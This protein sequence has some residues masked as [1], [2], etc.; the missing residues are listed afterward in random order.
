MKLPRRRFLHL[1]AGA[2][3]LPAVSRVA[4]AQ[5]YP[6]RPVHLIVGFAAGGPNDIFARLIAQWLSERLG[7]PFVIENRPGAASN[8][9]TEAVVRAA[10]DGLTLL[11]ASAANAVNATLY[12]HLNFDFIRDIAPVAGIART[13]GA[14]AVNPSL[15]VKTVAEFIAYA[16]ANPGKINMA[17]SGVGSAPQVWGELFKAMAGVDLT[18]VPY[19]SSYLPDLLSGQVQASF[20]PIAQTINFIRAGKLRA[21]A[22]TGATRSD[23]LPDVPAA[24]EFV[25][26]YDAYVWD[27]MG[28][29]AKTP[30]EIIDKLNKEIN[31]VLADPAMRAKLLDLG[32]EPMLMTPAE[33]G[34]YIADETEKWGKVVKFAHIKPD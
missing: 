3:A 29:P 4:S 8:T 6:T 14:M 23:V 34:K 2:A 13:Q 16:K 28:A 21:V 26:G 11:H 7:Q 25:P 30:P 17:T 22:V 18:N 31:A 27:A 19:K 9:A 1:A 10:P 32:A 20:T 33:F 12:D 5:T 24:N 15:P